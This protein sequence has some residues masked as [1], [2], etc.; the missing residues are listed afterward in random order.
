MQPTAQSAKASSALAA[1]PRFSPP[2][3]PAAASTDKMGR[4]SSDVNS[5][6]TDKNPSNE[7]AFVPGD[8]SGG[9]FDAMTLSPHER[10]R[11]SSASLR[12]TPAKG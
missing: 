7:W 1:A 8:A 6:Y 9:F 12:L 3:G 10:A 2:D 4:R 11:V 5:R